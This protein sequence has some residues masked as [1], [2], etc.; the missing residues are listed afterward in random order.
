MVSFMASVELIQLIR[1]KPEN[2]IAIK[3]MSDFIIKKCRQSI[4]NEEWVKETWDFFDVYIIPELVPLQ[5][6]CL[7]RRIELDNNIPI[8]KLFLERFKTFNNKKLD[9]QANKIYQSLF[10]EL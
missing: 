7:W 4:V 6:K 9:E 3:Q 5:V 1:A 10:D 8:K 2:K